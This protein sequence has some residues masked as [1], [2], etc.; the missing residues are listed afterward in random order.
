M[1]V[2][3]QTVCRH[4]GSP[5]EPGPSRPEGF[6]CNGCAYVYRLIHDSGLTRYYDL[7]PTTVSPVGSAPLAPQ[8]F[9][10]LQE[11]QERHETLASVSGARTVAATFHLRGI[12]CIGCTWIIEKV[13]TDTPGGVRAI[14]SPT[15]GVL[16]LEWVACA[17]DLP[18]FAR[19]LQGFGYIV[20]PAA[21]ARESASRALTGRLGLTAAFALNTML[22]TLP[23]YL[24]MGPDFELAGLFALLTVLFA[25]LSLVVGGSY[26]MT[27]A[28][29]SLRVGV[30]H[31]DLPIALGLILA[32]AGSSVGWILGEESFLYFDFVS[33]FTFLMLCG[34]WLQER[35]IDENRRRLGDQQTGPGTIERLTPSGPET[36]SATEVRTSDKLELAPGALLPVAAELLDDAAE[37]TLEWING[38]PEAR[39]FPTGRRVPAGARYI[40]RA[41]LRVRAV[42]H[43]E[44]SLLARLLAP[45]AERQSPDIVQTVLRIYMPTILLIAA[46]GGLSWTI[47]AGQAVT[48]W[49]V[50]LSILVISCP[51]AIG[52]ALPLADEL[53]AGR[54]QRRGIFVKTRDLYR[55]MD[56]VRTLI[57]DKTGTLTF[58]TPALTNP[59]P[60]EK[61]APEARGVLGQMVEESLHP[62]SR[63]IREHLLRHM[64]ANIAPPV[65]VTEVTGRGLVATDGGRSWT[66]GRVGWRGETEGAPASGSSGADVEFSEDGSVLA[67]FSFADDLRD[68]AR[69]TVEELRRTHEIVILSGDRPAKVAAMCKRLGLPPEAGMG[70]LAPEEKAEWV[71]SRPRGTTLF[72]GDGANDSLAFDEAAARGTPVINQAVLA[73]KADFYVLSRGLDGL[74]ELLSL[75]RRRNAAVRRA[76]AFTIVYNVTAIGICLTGAMNPLLAAILMPSSSLFS[77]AMISFALRPKPQTT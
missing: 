61:L 11:E 2:V 16:H 73:S 63:S 1:T 9:S 51:C 77:L 22:F 49:Q 26:F 47:F 27:R 32:Y 24:G 50:A 18:G 36:I 76:F 19:R 68:N 54:L 65:T 69:R 14:A 46:A 33:I 30:L 12:S 48:G 3:D 25:T 74:G 4:C 57:F 53:T 60:L 55:R 71:R 8:D 75:S 31:I 70:G 58:E 56:A 72:F 41:A 43:W 35:A 59:D 5:F 45:P 28:W 17:F 42:E 15:D 64:I 39:V 7:R 13:M 37:F 23:R 34:R 62:L 10:W 38:E 21:A 29:R 44:A 20:A 40:G 52:L 6:C 67:R 66:L